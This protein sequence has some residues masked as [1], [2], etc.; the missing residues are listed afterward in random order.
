MYRDSAL[1]ASLEGATI[2]GAS[3]H[4]GQTVMRA[5]GSEAAGTRL[6]PTLLPSVHPIGSIAH[7][8]WLAQPF[9]L[10][11]GGRQDHAKLL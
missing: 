7:G 8:D 10:H 4:P 9:S 5:R 3:G 6:N 1:R 2:N 11:D